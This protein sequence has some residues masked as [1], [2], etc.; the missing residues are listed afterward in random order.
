[1]QQEVAYNLSDL[2]ELSTIYVKIPYGINKS[3]RINAV[4]NSEF[5]DFIMDSNLFA[6]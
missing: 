2:W 1:M 5:Y 3:R 6:K 4:F